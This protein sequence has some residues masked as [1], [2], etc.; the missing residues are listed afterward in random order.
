M[1]D[2]YVGYDKRLVAETSRDYTTFQTSF[3][4]LRLVTLPM[5]WTNSVPIFHDNVTFILQAE[6]PHVTIPYIDDVP[7]KGPTT[8]YQKVDDS[9]ETILENPG[10]HRFV[11]KHFENLNRVVQRMKYCGGTF[12]GLKLFLCVP[13]IFVLGHRC[14]PEGRLPDESRISAIWKWGPCQSL[15]EVRTFLGT[16]GIVRVFIKNFSLCAHPLIKLTRKDEPFIFGPEKIQA[17]EDLKTA[18]L[19]SPALCAIDYTSS[20]PIILAVDTSYIAIGFHLCQCDVTTPSC[21]YYNRFCSITLNDR[22]SKYSQPKLK[23]YGLY[24]ALCALCHYLIG[25]RNLVVEVNV[26]Y[27]KGML[28]NPDIS[29]SASINRWIVAILTFHFDLVHI[30]G[31]HHGPDGLSRRPRQ[32]G[33]D[34]DRDDEEEFVDWIDQ[35]HGFLHQI[36]IVDI[37]LP[38]TSDS[39]PLPFPP[40]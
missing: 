5:G 33:D 3:G 14:T 38:T 9:Y 16:V 4:A 24:R 2:L 37:R 26:R 13:E 7:I 21:R 31:T 36:N 18:L 15:S 19:E 23:I 11:C 30:P 20:A 40:S 8:M 34:E 12:S 39:L 28:S 25:V 6:I 27:I 1:L 22:E 17:Q 35:L 32:V 10:I 29:P